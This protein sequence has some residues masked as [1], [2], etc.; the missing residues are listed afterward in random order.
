MLRTRV[1]TALVLLA[2][3]APAIFVLPPLVWAL[4]TIAAVAVAVHEW[5]GL[6]GRSHQ[7]RLWAAA[8]FAALALGWLAVFGLGPAP[9][10]STLLASAAALWWVGIAPLRLA[11]HKIGPGGWPVA[12][13]L[14][15]ACW[16][17]LLELRFQGGLALFVAMAIVWIADIGAYFVGRALGRRKLAPSISPGKSWEGAIGGALAV[18]VLG[19]LAAAIPGLEATLPPLLVSRLGVAGAGVILAALAALSVIG[20]LH[21]SLLKRRAGVKD[22]GRLLPGHGGVLDRVDA[23]IPTM[24]V[25]ILLESLLR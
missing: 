2:L 3:F 8:A 13:I 15:L 24:P 23:L 9:L 4:L 14:L 16:S 17:S 1:L 12:F 21:E 20:D 18:A 7:A 6:I 25:V 11:G 5:G 22:S 10:A 19:V